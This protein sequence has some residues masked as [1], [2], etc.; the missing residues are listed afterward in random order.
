MNS[1]QGEKGIVC[2]KDFT[3]FFTQKDEKAQL[4]AM[5]TFHILAFP[6]QIPLLSG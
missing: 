6:D 4:V 2:V 5:Y 1:Q 3:C